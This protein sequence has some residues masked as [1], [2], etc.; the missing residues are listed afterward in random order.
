MFCQGERRHM[1][2]FSL[3]QTGTEVTFEYSCVAESEKKGTGRQ[4]EGNKQVYSRQIDPEK[5]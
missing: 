3:G 4:R 2:C 1:S 5:D